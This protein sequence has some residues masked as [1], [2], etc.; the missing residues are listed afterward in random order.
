MIH[1][2][3]PMK[4]NASA[5]GGTPPETKA[6][7]SHPKPIGPA[8][9]EDFPATGPRKKLRPEGERVQEHANEPPPEAGEE[10][11]P[12]Y[13]SLPHNQNPPGAT[14][15]NTSPL[16]IFLEGL[17][18]GKWILDGREQD[19]TPLK[20]SELLDGLDHQN[21]LRHYKDW[22]QG[23]RLVNNPPGDPV[24]DFVLRFL[25]QLRNLN[26]LSL[27]NCSA[28]TDTGIQYIKD[29]QL[30][31]LDLNGCTQITDKSLQA[32]I[33]MPLNYLNLYGCSNITNKGLQALIGMSLDYLNLS[34]CSN[35]T[36]EGIQYLPESITQLD[37]S[38]C[39]ITNQVLR[40]LKDRPLTKLNLGGCSK[41]TN[42][43]IQYL[44]MSITQL[45][46]N[47]CTQITDKGLQHLPNDI[48]QLNLNYCREITDNGLQYLKD[49]PLTTLYL[50]GCNKITDH[51]LQY[52][53]ETLTTLDL[54]ELF[55]ITG[56][57]LEYLPKSIIELDLRGCMR[58]YPIMYKFL[59]KCPHLQKLRL[60][61][62][63]SYEGE[64]LKNYLNKYSYPVEGFL[65]L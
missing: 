5:M 53:P 30:T 6:P 63:S 60:P 1:N 34:G 41:I 22:I 57:G 58:I 4:R 59:H 49:K 55:K 19:F 32:L 38:R 61:D 7:E 31:F 62:W 42:E 44:P 16:Y 37:L 48:T 39:N 15:S 35:I 47:G 12:G 40:Y 3:Y 51:G 25:K 9:P 13:D 54:G 64:D 21:P 11:T 50:F 52:L 2:A 27:N 43:S 20:L 26:K 65:N 28:V 24:T 14:L 23:I 36:D 10:S 33:G 46:L 56:A 8:N 17:A 18:R 29:M 45:D